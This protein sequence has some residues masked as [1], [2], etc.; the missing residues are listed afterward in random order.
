MRATFADH[1]S[2]LEAANEY[3]IQYGEKRLDAL[4]DKIVVYEA[5]KKDGKWTQA[6]DIY[7]SYMPWG[8]WPDKLVINTKSFSQYKNS[9]QVVI[10]R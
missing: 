8:I 1:L 6:I 4:V 10:C 7:Y 2:H 3:F 5:V 9:I